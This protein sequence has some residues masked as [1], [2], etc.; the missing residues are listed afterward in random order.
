[1][2]LDLPHRPC[3]HA[4]ALAAGGW[5]AALTSP[6]ALAQNTVGATVPLSV[7]IEGLP[8][9]LA[10]RVVTERL[11]CG[12][13]NFTHVVKN[14]ELVL[15]AVTTQRF[16]WITLPTGLRQLQVTPVTRYVG[17]FQMP[18]GRQPG[19]PTIVVECNTSWGYPENQHPMQ[20]SLRV[21]GIVAGRPASQFINLGP[22]GV[23]YQSPQ[24]VQLN[25]TLAS[26]TEHLWSWT[27]QDGGLARGMRHNVQATFRSDTGAAQ[28]TLTIKTAPPQGPF[29]GISRTLAELFQHVDGRSCVKADGVVRCIGDEPGPVLHGN[30]RL[31]GVQ[32]YDERVVFLFELL[33]S[34]P[35]GSVQLVASARSTELGS[36]IGP[37][38]VV[39][40]P[41]LPWQA[42]T[43]TLR[44][45]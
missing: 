44:V 28:P 30:L 45:Q 39:P 24:P 42:K 34:F 33:Q 26:M 9:G 16:D 15:Q 41:L 40:A 12:D 18:Y 10:P 22:L 4:L 36:Y 23:R 29:L 5:L 38:G 2:S 31:W 21:D 37:G 1:M 13:G 8:A 17:N 25:R 43:M 32:R 6:A 19:D 14:P 27:A 3:L 11:F 20:M 7:S 35:T